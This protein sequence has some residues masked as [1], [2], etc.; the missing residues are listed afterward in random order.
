MPSAL[1]DF[2]ESLST[3]ADLSRLIAEHVQEDIHLELKTKKNRSVPD[4]EDSERWQF[5]RALSGFANSDG[6]I[7]I[8]AAVYREVDDF[9]IA[10]KSAPI[11][12]KGRKESVLTYE[13]SNTVL[14]EVPDIEI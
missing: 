10:R 11:T 6:G 12:V 9:V 13:V 8:S 2:F 4:L 1:E 3:A 5:W 7:L 14:D